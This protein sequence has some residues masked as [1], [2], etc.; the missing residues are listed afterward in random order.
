MSQLSRRRLL[1]AGTL[2]LISS[3]LGGAGLGGLSLPELLA[4]ESASGKSPKSCIFIH[5]YGGLSQLDSWDPKPDAPAEIRGPYKPIATATPG[6]QVGE[7]M[8]KLAKLSNEY[9][10]IRSM[11]HGVPVHEVANRMLLA[12]RDS[13]PA[14]SPSFGSIVS[15]LRPSQADVP[16]YVWLQKFGGGSAPA[17][18][19]Y[20]TGGFLGL[21][22]SPLLVGTTPDDNPATKG[23]RVKAFDT[24]EGVD[25]ARLQARRE[26]LEAL[27]RDEAARSGVSLEAAPSWGKFQDRAFQLLEGA[28]AKRAFDV[29]QEPAPMRDRYGRHPL[30]QNLLLARRLIEAGTRLVS[31]CGWCGLAPGDKFLSLETWDMHGNAGI[32]IFENGWNGLGWAMPCADQAVST[33]LEDLRERG[34]LESTLVVLVGEFGRT[35]RIGK[36]RAVGR[37]HWPN[38]YSAMIAGAGIRGGAVY[39]SSD[40]TAA[41]VKSKPVTLED[42]SATMFHALGI[43]PAT[44]LSPDGFTRPVSNGTPISQLF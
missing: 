44:R 17:E 38:C 27:N 33:L 19:A 4:A 18:Y 42:F 14:D 31:V 32:S 11:T 21:A 22:H 39:G 36:G 20:L 28:T 7:L 8:P 16:S 2:G 37:D 24:S 15:K 13:P 35:P 29:E 10:V 43:D 6:F 34:L 41:Y 5:Q 12:G 3:G 40:S 1:Q 26:M 30:G 23:F 25:A 9:C